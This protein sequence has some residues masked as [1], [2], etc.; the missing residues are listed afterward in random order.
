MRKKQLTMQQGLALGCLILVVCAV[1]FGIVLRATRAHDLEDPE[2]V[3]A[4]V[5]DLPTDNRADY[6][7]AAEMLDISTA[8]EQL[9]DRIPLQ[10]EITGMQPTYN[11]L[12]YT[13]KVLKT[14]DREQAGNTVVLYLLMS[15][16]KMSDGKLHCDAGIAL[17]LAV[18]HK[19]LLFVRPM[20]YMDLYQRTLPCREY[21]ATTNATDATLYSFCL[22]RT[23]TRP[24]P[25]T[26]L[27]F[28]QVTEYDYAGPRQKIHRRHTEALRRNCKI[29][30]K[31]P[32]PWV[33]NGVYSFP[34]QVEDQLVATLIKDEQPDSQGDQRHHRGIQQQ[35]PGHH[36]AVQ[37][38]LTEQLD[39]R[40]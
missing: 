22:D 24:L 29:T 26:P 6:D 37:N 2:K 36:L 8:V 10:V 39:H 5:C 38:T 4:A 12:R 11:N 32:L 27:T 14:T 1:V 7:A 9:Q 15:M 34:L 18:G 25:T 28:Q 31:A 40:I 3:A 13:A 19:Y 35:I 23:Q 16:E 21:Q 17:P 20:E 30:Q 33:G